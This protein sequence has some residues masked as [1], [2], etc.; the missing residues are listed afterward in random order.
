MNVRFESKFS[1]D[2]QKIREEKLLGKIKELI[3]S[4]KEA[5]SL[6]EIRQLRK[7]KGYDTFYR[8]RIGNYRVGLEV[9]GNDLIFVRCLH[10]KDVY[11]YFP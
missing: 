4:C 2:L 10:R 8:V 3:L 9:V 7:L 6:A 5:G 11:R 1:K